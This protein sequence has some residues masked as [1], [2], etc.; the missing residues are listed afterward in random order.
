MRVTL[1][2]TLA[3]SLL[4][5]FSPAARSQQGPSLPQTVQGNDGPNRTQL[6]A[7]FEEARSAIHAK[8]PG[9]QENVARSL[10]SYWRRH[11]AQTEHVGSGDAYPWHHH[12]M[13]VL[14]NLVGTDTGQALMLE[15]LAGDPRPSLR[16]VA[17]MSL[18]PGLRPL[19]RPVI[20][21]DDDASSHSI[22]PHQLSERN[23][24]SAVRL[25]LGL[26]LDD[27]DPR[28]PGSSS[29]Y[30]GAVVRGRAVVDVGP[31]EASF[32]RR[33]A[34]IEGYDSHKAPRSRKR[35]S[36]SLGTERSL[37]ICPK[38]SPSWPWWPT[39][40]APK[41]RGARTPC[42]PRQSHSHCRNRNPSSRSPGFRR[43][44]PPRPRRQQISLQ[45]SHQSAPGA[46]RIAMRGLAHRPVPDVDRFF[47]AC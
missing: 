30:V 26:A 2:T 36:A 21:R 32:I 5:M 18:G 42:L 19:Q 13:T 34:S 37:A 44:H 25:A 9:H 17:A 33:G 38:V 24:S 40:D 27:P 4:I 16:K 23:G 15:A 31:F 22:T 29:R 14:G 47:L 8:D 7:L 35:T 45:Y 3:T 43:P 41:L 6:R 1:A 12:L 10:V 11:H 20:S 28:G 46:E 39:A